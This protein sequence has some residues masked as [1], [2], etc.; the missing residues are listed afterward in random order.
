MVLQ[1]VVFLH[2]VATRLNG[3]LRKVQ[4]CRSFCDRCTLQINTQLD[5]HYSAPLLAHI[6][7]FVGMHLVEFELMGALRHTCRTIFTCPRLS[8]GHILQLRCASKDLT[9]VECLSLLI[10]DWARHALSYHCCR[11]SSGPCLAALRRCICMVLLQRG[12]VQ[13]YNSRFLNLCS[14]LGH[15]VCIC[16]LCFC[17]AMYKFTGGSCSVAAALAT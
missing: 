10:S 12:V 1:R 14:C 6:W 5:N 8:G 2:A 17:S 16:L 4:A 9:S 15:V 3:P 7:S 13:G 11:T